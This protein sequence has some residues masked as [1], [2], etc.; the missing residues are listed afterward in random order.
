MVDPRVCICGRGDVTL[1]PQTLSRT[2]IFDPIRIKNLKVTREHSPS[3]LISLISNGG[4][5]D[6]RTG[7][8][9]LHWAAG[10]GFDS[11]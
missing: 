1:P 10:T 5:C 3:K 8:S 7:S 9:S 2:I 6:K 11:A 4:G